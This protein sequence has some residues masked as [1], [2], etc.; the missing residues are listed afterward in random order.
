M[1]NFI[2]RVQYIV[3]SKQTQKKEIKRRVY[4]GVGYFSLCFEN[5]INLLVKLGGVEIKRTL[6]ALGYA[7]VFMVACTFDVCI[8]LLLDLTCALQ[9]RIKQVVNVATLNCEV[10]FSLQ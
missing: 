3:I 5:D 6:K 2:H 8:K 9:R 4:L 1:I 10:D 7:T